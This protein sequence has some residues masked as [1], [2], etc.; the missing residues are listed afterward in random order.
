MYRALIG[1]GSPQ[2]V[3]LLRAYFISS[4]SWRLQLGTVAHKIAQHHGAM[5]LHVRIDCEVKHNC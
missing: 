5:Q 4:E 1:Q 2:W 3:K